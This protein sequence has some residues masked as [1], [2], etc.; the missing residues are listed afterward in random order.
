VTR[1]AR[2]PRLKGAVVQRARDSVAQDS[3][4]QDSLAQDS[5]ELTVTGA[6][7]PDQ[8]HWTVTAFSGTVSWDA[9]A[10]P[11]GC[12]AAL[13]K[14]KVNSLQPVASASSA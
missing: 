11:G 9:P 6:G 7:M 14:M 2:A 8:R 3:L 10:L 13:Y 5:F 1:T 4:A 12:A